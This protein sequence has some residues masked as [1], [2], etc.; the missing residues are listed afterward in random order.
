MNKLGTI[1]ILRQQRDWVGGIRKMAIFADFQYYSRDWVGG[2]EKVQKYVDVIQ[3][4]PNI[5]LDTLLS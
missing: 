3:M 2:S 5:G 1:P 4:V